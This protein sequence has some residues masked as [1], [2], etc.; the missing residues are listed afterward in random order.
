MVTGMKTTM[1]MLTMLVAAGGCVTT[2]Q[3][4]L[5]EARRERDFAS[6]KA[7]VYRI[8][9]QA[10]SAST[11]YDQIY[12]EIERLRREQAGEDKE[13]ASRLDAV[14]ARL[15]KQD[16]AMQAMHKQIVAELSSKIKTIMKSQARSPGVEYGRE[17]LVKQGETLSEIAS[18]Y[19]VAINAVV[20][21]NGLKNANAIRVGQK[22]F[23]PE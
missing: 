5:E 6:L 21:A 13:L 23:I 1:L 10:G 4:R 12:A 15:R 9:E 20:R 11:G 8:K 19:G 22:L 14:E 2:Q 3:Q 18:A 16:A 17:H 7:D